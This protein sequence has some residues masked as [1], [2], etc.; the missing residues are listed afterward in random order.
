MIYLPYLPYAIKLL[1]YE[2]SF[3]LTEILAFKVI[4]FIF[5]DSFLLV[6]DVFFMFVYTFRPFFCLKFVKIKTNSDSTSYSD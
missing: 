5:I 4:E 3:I 1:K 2:K 6:F